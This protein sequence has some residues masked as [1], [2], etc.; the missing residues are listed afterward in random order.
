MDIDYSP[1]GFHQK[2]LAPLVLGLT[3]LTMG[4]TLLEVLSRGLMRSPDPL[5]EMYLMVMGGYVAGIEA[6]KWT[7]PAP[8]DPA[9]DPF[10]E[11]LHR[12]GAILLIWWALFI[13]VHLWRYQDAGVTMPASLKSITTGITLLFIGKRVSRQV[14]HKRR[15][16]GGQDA[17]DGASADEQLAAV[18]GGSASGLTL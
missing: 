7:Q 8:A 2:I 14:R 18:I 3:A 13:S 12:S 15:G 5:G 6:Q 10:M 17:G 16:V 1:D 4:E 11:R 9:N